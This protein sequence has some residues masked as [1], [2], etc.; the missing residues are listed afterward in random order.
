MSKRTKL[1]SSLLF[2]LC[3]GLALWGCASTTPKKNLN[4]VTVEHSF[5]DLE[6]VV[7]FEGCEY[8]QFDSYGSYDT[9]EHK[10]NCKNP[11]HREVIVKAPTCVGSATPEEERIGNLQARPQE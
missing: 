10:G 4:P 9:Y 6:G 1:I 5:T 2:F 7:E 8:F 3:V 11:I